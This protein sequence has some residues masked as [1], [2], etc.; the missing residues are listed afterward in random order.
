MVRALFRPNPDEIMHPGLIRA[1]ALAA[2]VAGVAGCAPTHLPFYL[3][4]ANSPAATPVT[5][6]DFKDHP[7]GYLSDAQRPD[8]K[9]FLPPPPA[10]GSPREAADR[11]TYLAMKALENSPRWAEARADADVE[12]PSATR[13]FTC[14][15]GKPI[16]PEATPA[17]ALLLARVMMDVAKAED[18]AKAEYARKRPFLADNG[19]TCTDKP[20]WLVKQGSYPSGHAAAGWAWALV[21]S[22]LE[23][24]RAD[25][26]MKRGMSY[27]ESR[28]V[29]RVH[30]A[31]DVEAGRLVGSAVVARLH[32]DP[33]FLADLKKA[34]AELAAA[35]TSAP[36]GCTAAAVR[37]GER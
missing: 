4:E 26:L 16:T 9:D 15:A 6:T 33:A 22:E 1:V 3:A 32:T 30:F 25:A 35:R 31:S 37:Q 27:G 24:D 18:G 7:Q 17:T 21:L 2:L 23:P 36:A 29:C 10:P 11:A 8:A 5:W 20:D 13:A 19:D 34:R 14:A 12:S 28:V